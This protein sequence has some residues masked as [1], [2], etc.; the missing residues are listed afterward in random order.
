MNPAK[1]SLLFIVC[2]LHLVESGESTQLNL[3]TDT[4]VDGLSNGY[5][6]ITSA[7]SPTM[8]ETGP[9]NLRLE[10]IDQHAG[11][12][13]GIYFRISQKVELKSFDVKC[14]FS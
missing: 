3:S 4:P 8:L 7:G 2:S 11:V 6:Q 1:Y 10:E 12:P 13:A 14:C 5:G 9:D